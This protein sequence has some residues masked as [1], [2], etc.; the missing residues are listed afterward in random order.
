MP[1]SPRWQW[2]SCMQQLCTG[3]ARPVVGRPS[4]GPWLL[5][6][7]AWSHP[8]ILAADVSELKAVCG[9][10][11]THR[12]RTALKATNAGNS[13]GEA[14]GRVTGVVFLVRLK[15]ESIV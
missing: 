13:L 9:T 8:G 14:G 1:A 6:P 7:A 12:Q 4:S 5:S 3:T 11:P 15:V 10:E 2:A